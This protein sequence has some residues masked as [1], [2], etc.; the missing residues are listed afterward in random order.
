[1]SYPCNVSD[2][3]AAIASIEESEN[4][5]TSGGSSPIYNGSS[6]PGPKNAAAGMTMTPKRTRVITA[7][8]SLTR[9]K[10]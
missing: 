8:D 9:Q 2:A 6:S 10:K 5:R 7:T 4:T 3:K 1:M